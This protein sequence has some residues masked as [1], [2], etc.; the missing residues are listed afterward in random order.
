MSD[1][2]NGKVTP[3]DALFKTLLETFFVEFVEL[4]FPEIFRVMDKNYVKFLREEIIDYEKLKKQYVDIFVETK[5]KGEDGIVLIHVESQAQR[6]VN[7]NSR[8]YNYFMELYKKHRRIIIPIVIYSHETKVIE[9]DSFIIE[10]PFLKILEFKFLK[11]QLRKE[12]W[13]KYIKS[14]N[15]VAAALIS[16]MDWTEKE[17]IK[18]KLEFLRM[19][20]RMRLDDMKT[21]FLIKF[22]ETYLPITEKDEEFFQMRIKN[23]F[24]KKEV[25]KCMEFVSSYR[26]KGR[27]EGIEI[28]RKEGKMIGRKEGVIEGKI[29]AMREIAKKMLLA[30]MRI[31]KVMEFTGLSHDE[32]QKL[33]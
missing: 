7:Y 2:D 30:K 24:E 21:D 32:V 3:H 6:K 19:V 16:K 29:E 15:P 12:S 33:Q 4:F 11:I 26:L 9:P 8:M 10:L 17:K 18:V 25:K 22:F 5:L 20:T 27:V 28:G 31:S 1:L 23:E 14:N 13:K